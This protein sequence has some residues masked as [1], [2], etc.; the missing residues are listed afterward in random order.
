MKRYKVYGIGAALVDTE[1]RVDDALLADLGV[2][3]GLMT[4]VD[5]PRRAEL[6]SAL[7]GHL[8][9]AHH[10][11]GGSAGN[12]MI[13]TAL[14]GGRCFMSCRVADDADGAIYLSDLEKA[15]VSYPPP[16][17]AEVPTGKCLVLVT[18]DAERSMNTFLGASEGLSIEQLVP[19][20]IA[21]S[22]FL[23]I[24][25]YLVSSETGLAAAVR[26]RELA[27]AAGVPVA[28]SFSDPGMVQHFPEQFRQIVGD[29]VDLV[30][31]ND[32]EARSW[33]GKEDLTEV[34]AALRGTAERFAIT[35]GAEGALCF[36]GKDMHEIP[37]H[38]VDAVDSNGAGDMFAG[39]F[40]YALTRGEDFPTAGRFASVAAGTVVSQ[41][42]PRLKLEQYGTLR[43]EFFVE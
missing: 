19:E 30:F 36:D 21:D 34:A 39:A 15:G 20:A 13:A 32:A 23:Y 24:E 17:Q 31:A 41:W 28:V 27:Q 4:L 40:L 7:D 9:A 5:R 14:F 35:R 33:T 11:S 10:A 37:V 26:A 2:E 6:L 42:G 18:E 12:S 25:G 16:V 3:K 22:E 1:I 43:D 38:T 8:V 29:G